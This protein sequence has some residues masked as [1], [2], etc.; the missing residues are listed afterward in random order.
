M[1]KVEVTLLVSDSL[2][3]T[4]GIVFVIPNRISSRE[5]LLKYPFA[6][7]DVV[8]F[9][10]I[11]SEPVSFVHF[12]APQ[13]NYTYKFEH[14]GRRTQVDERQIGIGG[15]GNLYLD[16]QGDPVFTTLSL[17][18]YIYGDDISLVDAQGLQTATGDFMI[19]TEACHEAAGI[20]VCFPDPN[21]VQIVLEQLRKN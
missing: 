9:T 5:F 1:P 7:T 8:L 6:E 20:K 12:D 2:T 19:D 21:Q 13:R 11:L 14:E 4:G 10:A 16:L 18:H 17:D 3:R 15:E